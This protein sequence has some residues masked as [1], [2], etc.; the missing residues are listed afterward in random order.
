MSTAGAGRTTA[1]SA[2]A[3]SVAAGA[4]LARF[5]HLDEAYSRLHR[6]GPEFGEEGSENGLANH[7]PMAAEI[8]CRRGLGDRVEPWLDRYV[9]RLEELP[10]ESEPIT[11]ETWRAA[12][13]KRA[14]IGDWAAYFDRA[15][16]EAS[17]HEVLV[18]WWPRLLPAIASG[19]THG[20]IRTGHAVR[21]IVEGNRS[22]AAVHELSNAL[23]YW[24]ARAIY[25][26]GV[27]APAGELDADAAL[28][29]L[30]RLPNQS[31]VIRD[32]FSRLAGL[33]SWT[34]AVA[35]LRPPGS[36]DEVPAALLDLT[37]AG[38]R[39]YAT[40]GHASPVLLVHG[41]TAPHAMQ[42]V[43]PVLPRELWAP[44]LAATWAACAALTVAY[45]PAHGRTVEVP[46]GLEPEELM[47]RAARHG[48]EHVIKLTDAVL[49]T[50][51]STGD[52]L[53]LAAATACAERIAPAG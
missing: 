39:Q 16:R 38:V 45:A 21:N 53:M 7:A 44:S 43:L 29:G 33:A 49:D 4:R 13:G 34:P 30:P 15:V 41:A 3:R 31:G 47:D 42:Q 17:W 6:W 27:A 14:R 35:S 1:V 24:A 46:D 10:R 52:P 23:G 25:V 2:Q 8:L 19:A 11:C 40:H 37:A 22:E 5:D 20:L 48:D 26:P 9:A 36:A 51:A 32:R 18:D 12:M 28:A 50:Y